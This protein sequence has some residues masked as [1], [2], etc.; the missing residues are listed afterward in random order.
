[1]RHLVKA[2]QISFSVLIFVGLISSAN[3]DQTINFTLEQIDSG[4]ALYQDH[5]QICHGTRLSN[6]QFG[7]PLKGAYFRKAWGEKSVGELLSFVYESMPP[8][9][10][11]SLS[12]QEY[13]EVLAFI[14]SNNRFDASD[15]AIV[16]DVSTLNQIIM[17]W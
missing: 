14:L 16:G 2:W 17:S 15:T 8:D 7:T 9:D 13:A 1:M 11:K 3:A 5:C 6:G 10:V 4:K 12:H